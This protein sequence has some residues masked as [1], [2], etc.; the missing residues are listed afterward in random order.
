M[1]LDGVVVAKSSGCAPKD[2]GQWR[3]VH[4]TYVLKLGCT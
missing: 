2:S 3:F 1:I 4:A